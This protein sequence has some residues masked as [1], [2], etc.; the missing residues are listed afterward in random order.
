MRQARQGVVLGVFVDPDAGGGGAWPGRRR[1]FRGGV[2]PRAD[3]E[4]SARFA[5]PARVL[6]LRDG[7]GVG[8]RGTMAGRRFDLGPS[9]LLELAGSGLRVVVGSLR[10]QLH[11]PRD[12]G[13]ARHRH[14]RGRAAWW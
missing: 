5:A 4:F 13:D 7:A 3:S 1:G 6:A 2:Q 10:R 9:A 11:E 14:R 8:R 12:A